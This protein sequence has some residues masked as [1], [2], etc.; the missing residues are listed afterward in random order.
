M[1]SIE[2][3]TFEA[4]FMF[5]QKAVFIFRK[6]QWIGSGGGPSHCSTRAIRRVSSIIF[7]VGI[8]AAC[9]VIRAFVSLETV[10]NGV[11]EAF[12]FGLA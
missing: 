11:C 3:A 12:L 5:V 7:T 1:A 6:F 10:V 9:W 4:T 2:R 8:H